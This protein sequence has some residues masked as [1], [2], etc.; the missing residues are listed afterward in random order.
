MNR[1]LLLL[2]A[3]LGCGILASAAFGAETHYLVL[4]GTESTGSREFAQELVRLWKLPG[5]V[6]DK[7]SQLD[8]SFA[9][10]PKSRLEQLSEQRGDLA[11]V[12]AESAQRW[13]GEFPKVQVLTVLWTNWLQVISANPELLVLPADPRL[14]LRMHPNT[15]PLAV[16]W[17]AQTHSGVQ[18]IRWESL[19]PQTDETTW[20]QEGAWMVLAPAPAQEIHQL[21]QE[22]PLHRLLALSPQLRQGLLEAAPWMQMGMLPATTYPGQFQDIVLPMQRPVLVARHDLQANMVSEVLDLLFR[23]PQ[24]WQ[25]HPLFRELKKTHNLAFQHRYTFHPAARQ[26]LGF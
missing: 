12:D 3:V 10:A 17:G 21:L 16:V 2:A 18:S 11:I 24:N 22:N 8:W 6:K 4:G 5:A 19:S 25:P 9:A 15:F 7:E 14:T 13:L 1:P 20:V 23:Q 26:V